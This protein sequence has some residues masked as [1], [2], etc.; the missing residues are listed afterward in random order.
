MSQWMEP[1]RAGEGKL[2]F[3]KSFFRFVVNESIIACWHWPAL[4]NRCSCFMIESY[5]QILGFSKVLGSFQQ[6]SQFLQLKQTHLNGHSTTLMKI[7][8][9]WTARFISW[10]LLT[11]WS[12]TFES[13][14]YETNFMKI[15]LKVL[16]RVMELVSD[17][18]T[19]PFCQLFSS[20]TSFVRTNCE[21]KFL[22]LGSQLAID[23]LKLATSRQPSAFTTPSR[24]DKKQVWMKAVKKT[25]SR[26][27][28]SD[29]EKKIMRKRLWK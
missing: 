24:Q 22:R 3:S 21:F 25:N 19:Q 16:C 1:G 10:K 29:F 20:P 2:I 5:S 4:W 27:V 8:G 17:E 18:F 6:I 12:F 7:W 23:Y 9:F 26:K 15:S 11:W 13:S 14:N 28:D